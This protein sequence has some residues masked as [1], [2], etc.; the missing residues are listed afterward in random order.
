MIHIDGSLTGWGNAG[1]KLPSCGLWHN[2]E[3]AHAY[4]LE[5]KIIERVM[6]I[7]CKSRNFSRI[8]IMCDNTVSSNKLH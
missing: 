1:E 4:I 5:L 7:Y 3:I 2:T 6:Q 8:P